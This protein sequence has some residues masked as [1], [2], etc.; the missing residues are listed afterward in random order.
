MS[1]IKS[2]TFKSEN[3]NTKAYCYSCSNKTVC[4][5]YPSLAG[6]EATEIKEMIKYVRKNLDS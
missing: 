3:E 6:K 2:V 4:K 5:G 1:K